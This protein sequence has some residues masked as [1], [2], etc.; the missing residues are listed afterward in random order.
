[1]FAGSSPTVLI[2]EDSAFLAHVPRPLA[3]LN[4][5]LLRTSSSPSKNEFCPLL[6]AS[7]I[8]DQQVSA[9]PLTPDKAGALSLSPVKIDDRTL[10]PSSEFSS[11]NVAAETAI[12]MPIVPEL[13][14]NEFS[15]PV[16]AAAD[17]VFTTMQI[18]P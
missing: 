13:E 8:L 2:K 9:I 4:E 16:D 6:N 10:L 18:A 5:K 7:S 14:T 11:I 3:L 1:M 12:R 17:D 15:K